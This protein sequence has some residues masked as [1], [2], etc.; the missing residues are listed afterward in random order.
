V[1]KVKTK[2]VGFVVD[3]TPLVDITFLLLTFFMF[4]AKFKTES[5]AAQKFVIQRPAVTAD[6]SKLPTIDLA[7]IKIAIDTIQFDTT[8]HYE[9]SNEVDRNEVWR[10]VADYLTPEDLN[11]LQLEVSLELLDLLVRN[12]QFVNRETKYAIDADKNLEFKKVHDA[13]NILRTN[14]ATQFNYVTDR[15]GGF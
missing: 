9:M 4:T 5:E 11:S 6:T 7:I 14:R 12:T 13:M 15:K 8:Y 2:R 10:R 3:M 1:A